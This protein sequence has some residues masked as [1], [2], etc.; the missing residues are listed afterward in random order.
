VPAPRDPQA[1]A[2]VCLA[3]QETQLT[4]PP[5]PSQPAPIERGR[6]PETGSPEWIA[7]CLRLARER[8]HI[9]PDDTTCTAKALG[10]TA[11]GWFLFH[12]PSHDPRPAM[13]GRLYRVRIRLSDGACRCPCEASAHTRTE[14]PCGHKGSA[15]HYLRRWGSRLDEVMWPILPDDDR[16]W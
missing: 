8:D 15:I 3:D 6:W 9:A 11:S 5:S 2:W 13:K 1:D 4:I 16:E 14:R 12:V 10:Y 7:A